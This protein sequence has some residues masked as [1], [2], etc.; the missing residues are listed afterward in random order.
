MRPHGTDNQISLPLRVSKTT[1]KTCTD[2]T[3]A[4]SSYAEEDRRYICL[5]DSDSRG[6]TYVCVERLLIRIVIRLVFWG[7]QPVF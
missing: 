3:G 1:P 7:T 5:I 6:E 2:R 4:R